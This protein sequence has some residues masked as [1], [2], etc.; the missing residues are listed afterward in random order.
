MS[1]QIIRDQIVNDIIDATKLDLTDDYTFTGDVQVPSTPANSGS[2]ASKTY[3]DSLVASGS[4]WKEAVKAA[5][6][7]AFSGAY[8]YNNG[9]ITFNNNGAFGN[10]DG[11]AIAENDR[12]LVKDES[13]AKAPN[14]GIYTLTTVGDAG[15]PAALT[16][17]TD[18]DTSAE[19][20]G[21]TVA[22]LQGTV[23]DN[24]VFH[25]SNDSDPTVGTTDITFVQIDNQNVTGGNGIAVSG[26]S[27]AVDLATTSA[28]T[29]DTNKL[30]VAVNDGIE[31]VSDSLKAKV[32]AGGKLVVDG[33]GLNLGTGVI[34]TTD[35]AA[36][37]LGAD[38]ISNNAITN[39]KLDNDAVN[40][41]EIV[42]SAVT[43]AKIASSAVVPSKLSFQS[44][45]KLGT[46]DGSTLTLDLDYEVDTKF[47]EM[48]LVHRNGL[49]I[50]S[51]ASPSNVDEY[52]VNLTGGAGGNSRITFGGAPSN[53]DSITIRYLA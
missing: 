31:I 48:I 41:D 27:I 24:A 20:K 52:S 43:S 26:N 25:C 16:R 2:A 35:I 40:S 50:N 39:A 8:V 46:G 30:K 36:A 28:L 18:M 33:D 45:Q 10:L 34:V 23:N 11:V 53:S 9:V 42:A 3:V 37:G 44:Y 14:N 51:A 12:I 7:G 32:K 21:S 6:V 15:T 4:Y 47:K 1:T 5:S 49:L 38:A 22:V 13:A 19:F 17:S 29:F